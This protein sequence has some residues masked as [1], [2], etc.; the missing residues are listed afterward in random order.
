MYLTLSLVWLVRLW[1]KWF[2]V[3]LCG[4]PGILMNIWQFLIWSCGVCSIPGILMNIWQFIL[5]H[6]VCSI[7]VTG[8]LMNTWQFI[9]WSLMY[10]AYQVFWWT[11]D[12]L[13]YDH[14]MYLLPS[15]WQC[16]PVFWNHRWIAL[17]SLLEPIRVIR[18]PTGHWNDAQTRCQ[19]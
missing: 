7:H 12:S 15:G 2:N 5:S 10:V 8:I 19:R 13:S 9:I 3:W 18:T 11:F 16:Y 14:M 17:C 4:I 6:D 1:I